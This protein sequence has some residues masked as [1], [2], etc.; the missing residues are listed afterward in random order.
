MQFYVD[1][2]KENFINIRKNVPL[3][4]VIR[5]TMWILVFLYNKFQIGLFNPVT[6]LF[7]WGSPEHSPLGT[8]QIPLEQILSSTGNGTNLLGYGQTRVL[9]FYLCTNKKTH[10]VG[11]F[12]NNL[13]TGC[14]L[15]R[16]SYGVPQ[17]QVSAS[18][19]GYYYTFSLNNKYLYKIELR[20]ALI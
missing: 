4:E 5:A 19:E 20:H 10:S 18:K 11:P 15:T 7:H 8:T 6:D 3:Q 2:S 12:S 1:T 16:N 9:S 13:W 14:S 17:N